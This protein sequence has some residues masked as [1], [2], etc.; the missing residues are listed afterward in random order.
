M[1]PLGNRAALVIVLT[2]VLTMFS[3]GFVLTKIA[4]SAHPIQCYIHSSTLICM[5]EA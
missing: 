1:E 2:L 5:P 4:D 3:T